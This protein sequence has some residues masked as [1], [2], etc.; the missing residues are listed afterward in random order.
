VLKKMGYEAY[1]TDNDGLARWQNRLTGYIH[2]KS[3][4]KPHQR[5][6]E[7]LAE[8]DWNVPRQDVAELVKK[9]DGKSVFVCGSLANETDLYDLFDGVFALHVNEETLAHRLK[10][11]TTNDW[12]KQPHELEQTLQDHRVSYAEHECRGNAI[13]DATQP[14]DVVV[15]D[16]LKMVKQ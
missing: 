14:L 11:R 2:P 1:D 12:G 4:V 9:A 3:S 6:P 15:S 13:V 16:I 7:F 8:H 5:T 10:T